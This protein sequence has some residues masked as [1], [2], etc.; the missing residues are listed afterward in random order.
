MRTVAPTWY[1]Q[2]ATSHRATRRSPSCARGG[3]RLAGTDEA[4]ARRALF[5]DISRTRPLVVFLDDLHWADVSTIDILNYLARRFAD[6]RVLVLVSYRPSEMALAQNRFS[7]IT[8]DLRSRGCSRH[9]PLQF[10]A[11]ADVER[12]LA[13]EFPATG[14][15]RVRRLPSHE[16]GRQPALHGG[17]GALSARLRQHRRGAGDLGADPPDCQPATRSAGIGAQHDRA[18]DRAGRRARSEAAARAPACRDTSSIRPPSREA[19]G[20]DP[21]DVEERL[22]VLERVHAFVKRGSEEE[23]PDRTLTVKYQFVHVLYQNLLY[24]SLQPTQRAALSGRVARALVAHYGGRTARIAGAAGRAL[25]GGSRFRDG[26]QYYFS[27]AQHAVGA[28]RIPGS[29]LARRSRPARARRRAGRARSDEQEL[30]L[31]M[32]RGLALRAMKGWSSPELE[33]VFVR[34][35]ELC[36]QL[37]DPPELFPV[38]WSIDALVRHSRRSA[39]IPDTRRPT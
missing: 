7:S 36:H 33:P 16:D 14:S 1:L 3:G 31:Q 34:A 35:R 19:T 24:G 38:L 25:R 11:Q 12:Y 4:G 20:I 23:F 2:V 21:I 5:E 39:R 27:A 13:L 37:Q 8:T 17:S 30:R 6:M 29:A 18:E 26:A 22:D 10:L 15:R 32:V 28:L 9:L